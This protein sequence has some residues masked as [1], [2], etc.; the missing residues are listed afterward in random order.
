MPDPM[1][2]HPITGELGA[3][4]LYFVKKSPDWEHGAAHAIVEVRA[5]KRTQV[6][7]SDGKPVYGDDRDRLIPDHALDVVRYI[8]NSRPL[9]ASTAPSRPRAMKAFAKQEGRVMVTVP[10]IQETAPR[11]SRERGQWK[12]H[13]NG[14]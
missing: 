8:V 11:K 3:P 2:R 4:H 13:F 9:A 7:E 14:Y 12:S 6:G 1:H 10:P 5:A